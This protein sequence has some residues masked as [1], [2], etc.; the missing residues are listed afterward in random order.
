MFPDLHIP[1]HNDAHHEHHKQADTAKGLRV[2]GGKTQF[3]LAEDADEKTYQLTLDGR[4]ANVRVA[5]VRA[6]KV[7]HPGH[8]PPPLRI[9]A[10]SSF[11]PGGEAPDD[12][13]GSH[14]PLIPKAERSSQQQAAPSTFVPRP[15]MPPTVVSQAFL[16]SSCGHKHEGHEH[17]RKAEP[18]QFFE[19]SGDQY[20]DLSSN[21]GSALEIE[22]SSDISLF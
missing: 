2:L 16:E 3:F 19:S 4:G 8:I 7:G 9:F 20:D 21:V 18:T 6:E 15:P 17:S 13:C 1:K 12:G 11:G 10:Q 5:H 14:C 22:V